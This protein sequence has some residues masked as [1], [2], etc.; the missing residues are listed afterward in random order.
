MAAP[1]TVGDRIAE[2]LRCELY[3]SKRAALD[4]VDSVFD[5]LK[6]CLAE[7]LDNPGRIYRF[8]NGIGNFKGRIKEGSVARNPRTGEPV[9]TRKRVRLTVA[10]AA[11]IKYKFLQ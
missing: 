5:E 7:A 2:R 4:I 8:P 11:S 10:V 1:L 9:A 3:I 6:K